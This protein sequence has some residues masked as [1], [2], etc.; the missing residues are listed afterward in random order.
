MIVPSEEMRPLLF[1]VDDNVG[2][3][4]A[5]DRIVGMRRLE[6]FDIG[7]RGEEGV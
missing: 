3:E 7:T 1:A 2:V 6:S 4:C 5:D